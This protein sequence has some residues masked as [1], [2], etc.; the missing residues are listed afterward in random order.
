MK[1]NRNRVSVVGWAMTTAMLLSLVMMQASSAQV[2]PGSDELRFRDGRVVSGQLVSFDG[3]V[4]T[5]RTSQETLTIPREQVAAVFIGM[6]GVPGISLPPF[7]SAGEG[8]K[9]VRWTTFRRIT[10]FQGGA[11]AKVINNSKISANGSK[12][13][14]STYAGTYT[15]NSD[16]TNLILLS[17]KRNEG[18]ID[19]S[20]DS[21]KVAWG[22]NSGLFVANSDGTGQVK[23][24]GGF[25][26]ISMRMTAMGDRLIVLAPERGIL[27]LPTDGSDVRRVATTAEVAKVA[28]TDENGN[29]WRG[30]NSGLDISNDGSRLVFHFLWDAFAMNSNGT[31]LRKLTQFLNPENR[32]LRCVRISG[33]GQKI[34]YLNQPMDGNQSTLAFLD[35]DGGNLRK[36]T[37]AEVAYGDWMQCSAD[38]SK[39]ALSWGLRLHDSDGQGKLDVAYV[40][41]GT[42]T[43]VDRACS[44][45]MTADMRRV[46]L[47]LD[48]G[49]SNQLVVVDF[50]PMTLTGAPPLN[51]LSASPRFLLTDGATN[52]ILSAQTQDPELQYV[53]FM[54]MRAGWFLNCSYYYSGLNDEG[55]DGDQ[56]AKDGTFGNNTLRLHTDFKVVP[57][58]L[59][60]RFF[61]FNR[62]GHMLSVDVEG[63]EARN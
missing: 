40:G 41:P 55:R 30:W 11:D 20:S 28:G 4:F 50:N 2:S 32:S 26:V 43:S 31:E 51:N 29:H 17:D 8:F 53:G 57:G 7:V 16:G 35:W 62:A 1:V 37:G 6:A 46:C 27:M 56:T 63:L 22:D 42:P 21:K 19:I 54:P 25:Q 58:P 52:T 38:G 15:I 36:F 5:F 10:N 12:I 39:V 18:L 3:R 45:T 49:P 9:V 34:A 13:V 14:F 48:I 47:R 24:P 33:N 44:A 23:M 59:T 61:A 60:L